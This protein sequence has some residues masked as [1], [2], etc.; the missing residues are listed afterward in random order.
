MVPDIDCVAGTDSGTFPS[1]LAFE[2]GEEGQVVNGCGGVFATCQDGAETYTGATFDVD[3]DQIPTPRWSPRTR[4]ANS[5]T[6][7]VNFVEGSKLGKNTGW[8]RYDLVDGDLVYR[9][10]APSRSSLTVKYAA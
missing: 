4:C 3:G 5:T 9:R 7:F 6:T 10:R 2:T 8:T 1:A